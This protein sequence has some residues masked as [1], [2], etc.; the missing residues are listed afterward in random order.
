MHCI[1]TSRSAI[2]DDKQIK[3]Y[4]SC[5]DKQ[6]KDY[7]SCHD[8]QIKGYQSCH[9]KQIKGYHSCHD[10]QIRG[11]QSCHDK[12]T[13]G[14]QSYNDK[15]IKGYRSC[16]DKQI[17]FILPTSRTESSRHRTVETDTGRIEHR[18][19][20]WLT[21]VIADDGRA[22]PAASLLLTRC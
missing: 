14:Y 21:P 17:R 22:T 4:Q 7:Q 3:G 9:D 19:P 2:S 11:Y 1:M 16:H 6:I 10:K 15:Q 12:Q 20:A 13:K 5:H 18:S 8:K